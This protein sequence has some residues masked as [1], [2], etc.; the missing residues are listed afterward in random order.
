MHLEQRNK[1][2]PNQRT[3]IAVSIQ[4]SEARMIIDCATIVA[5]RENDVCDSKYHNNGYDDDE[6]D[7]IC[8]GIQPRCLHF[9]IVV[10]R[11]QWR[12]II[13]RIV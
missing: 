13:L 12:I 2:A 11:N 1:I 8:P 4:V 10:R 7:L 9:V 6:K 3:G 5:H